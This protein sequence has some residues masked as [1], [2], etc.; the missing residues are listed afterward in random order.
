MVIDTMILIYFLLAGI[1]VTFCGLLI[2]DYQMYKFDVD[3]N[4][5]RRQIDLITISNY[6]ASLER[7]SIPAVVVVDPSEKV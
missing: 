1:F 2:S 5:A 3:Q 7:R 4:N 6:N